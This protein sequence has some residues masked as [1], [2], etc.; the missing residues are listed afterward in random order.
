MSDENGIKVWD[1]VDKS[2]C[3]VSS[4]I[5]SF[6]VLSSPLLSPLVL[7][8]P[9]SSFSSP[10]LSS[11]P[12]YK[13]LLFSF[14]HVDFN[15]LSPCALLLG[16]GTQD[17]EKDERSVLLLVHSLK[18]NLVKETGTDSSRQRGDVQRLWSCIWKKKKS[19]RKSKVKPPPSCAGGIVKQRR[20]THPL[21][22]LITK[23]NRSVDEQML[24]IYYYVSLYI[25][26][27][28]VKK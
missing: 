9:L 4:L 14:L 12:V 28:I 6:L 18:T 3:F 22:V 8:F 11:P 19:S 10:L 26:R 25:S 15:L 16:R 5:L 27:E 1:P 23:Q 24:L 17:E 21:V 20:F 2:L 7:S 13:L